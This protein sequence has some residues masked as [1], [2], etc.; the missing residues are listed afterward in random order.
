VLDLIPLPAAV[1]T[2]PTTRVL[3]W[4]GTRAAL[5]SELTTPRK[6]KL[7]SGLSRASK[8]AAPYADVIISPRPSPD[9]PTRAAA[10][11]FLQAGHNAP[12]KDC[13]VLVVNC[14][15]GNIIGV[16]RYVAESK[17]ITLSD[18]QWDDF[19]QARTDCANIAL[20]L[21]TKS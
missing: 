9:Q 21:I 19:R 8:S 18:G 2:R 1:K 20:V 10:Q 3:I 5:L 4:R 16:A 12:A 7:R 14:H 17:S 6:S 11:W 15:S 13:E